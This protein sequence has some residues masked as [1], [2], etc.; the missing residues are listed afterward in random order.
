MEGQAQKAAYC[1]DKTEAESPRCLWNAGSRS[2]RPSF[3]TMTTSLQGKTRLWFAVAI[4]RFSHTETPTPARTDSHAEAENEPRGVSACGPA[5]CKKTLLRQRKRLP[6]IFRMMIII[7][8]F[9]KVAL[10]ETV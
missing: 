2:E 6:R 10:M 1:G 5:S 8:I 7:I 3:I 4:A 9:N